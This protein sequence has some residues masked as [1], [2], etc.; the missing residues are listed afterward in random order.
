[1]KASTATPQ[2]FF[3]HPSETRSGSKS[4]HKT[5]KRENRKTRRCWGRPGGD[6][7]RPGGAGE[8]HH[9]DE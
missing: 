8:N 7:G 9:L 3:K 5:V 1:V 6:V 2:P 4:R